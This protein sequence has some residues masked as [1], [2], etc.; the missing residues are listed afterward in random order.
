MAGGPIVAVGDHTWSSVP[1][2][3]GSAAAA[4]S[5]SESYFQKGQRTAW[6]GLQQLR[7]Q[8]MVARAVSFS[9]TSPC[10]S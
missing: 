2:M 10:R 1:L 4:K 6:E 3:V 9:E 8:Q 5:L 7:Y